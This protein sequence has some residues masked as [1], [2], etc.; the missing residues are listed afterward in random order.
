MKA[1]IIKESAKKYPIIAV[2]VIATVV[3]FGF[4]YFRGGLLSEQRTAVE[5]LSLES[6][7][8]NQNIANAAQLQAQVKFLVDANRAAM[9]RSLSAAVPA[10]NIQYFYRLES[11]VGLK[12][13]KLN[14][15]THNVPSSGKSYAPF[16]HEV[17]LDGTFV[18][19]ITFLH[20]LEQGAYFC[21]VRRAALS[22]N[23]ERVTL[24]L[25]FDLL[26]SK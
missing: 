19:A 17:S 9:E 1:E 2:C 23:G 5:S 11:E 25:N 12:N 21:R 20:Q 7:R 16:P 6:N 10:Q 13:I 18:Q 3:L 4:L 15:G 8:Y 26:G 14:Y 22:L 24:H